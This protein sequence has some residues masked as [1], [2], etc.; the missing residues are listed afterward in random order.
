MT[1]LITRALV[2][3]FAAL[4]A[5]DE[6]T[7]RTS[8]TAPT[9]QPTSMPADLLWR[10]SRSGYPD[11]IRDE[12]GYLRSVRRQRDHYVSMALDSSS[13]ARA[14]EYELAA[15]NLILT[16]ETEPF[17]S[18]Y[19]LGLGDHVG[20]AVRTTD[21]QDE[22][23][24][25]STLASARE[26]LDAAADVLERSEQ[27]GSA[28]RT[29]GAPEDV[30]AAVRTTNGA[31]RERYRATLETLQAF[32]TALEAVWGGGGDEAALQAR[33]FGVAALAVLLEHERKDVASAATLW[34]AVLYRRMG[35]ADKAFQLL[36]PATARVEREARTWELYSRLLRCRL[37]ADGGGYAAAASLLMQIEERVLEWFGTDDA[38]FEAA[39]AAM[40]VRLQLLE[41]WHDSLNPSTEPDEI[42]WCTRVIE[43]IRKALSAEH[44]EVPLL[45]L[46][47]TIPLIAPMPEVP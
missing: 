14:V 36:P 24:I 17:A 23:S 33:R 11:T 8:T 41:Q 38:R 3:T 5:Q 21:A 45:R 4:T 30:G 20:P 19:L 10:L 42:D 25:R 7:D 6:A 28:T 18:R 16:R 39:H 12:A 31:E 32:A 37:L 22:V 15:A 26:R 29:T 40:F 43:R 47:H 44:G 27:V 34:Q 35:R 9:T 13:P 2:L 1:N 46:E